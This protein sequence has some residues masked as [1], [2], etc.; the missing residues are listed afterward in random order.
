MSMKAGP[1][2]GPKGI[3]VA[4]AFAA[5]WE[6]LFLSP[7]H[8]DSALSKQEKNMKSILARSVPSI[9]QRPVSQAEALGIGVPEGE[10][11][12]LSPEQASKWRPAVLMAERIYEGMANRPVDASPVREDFPPWMVEEWE[13]H[14]GPDTSL[15]LIEALGR[16]APLS[17]R[18]AR[19]VGSKELLR[20]L[21]EGSRLP[22]AAA[23]SDFA[24]LGVRLAGYAPVLG[25]EAYEKGLFE[26]QDEGSQVMALF[27]L[28]PEKFAPLLRSVPGPVDLSHFKRVSAKLPDD[29]PALTV[30][31]ACAGAGGKSLALADA[32]RGKGRIFSY[33]ISERKLQALRRR[34]THAGYNNIQAVALEEGKEAETLRKFRRTAQVVLVDA[35]CTGWGVLRRNPDIKWRQSPAALERLPQVQARLLSTYSDLV[36]PGGRLV[37]G[38]CTFRPAETSKI[39]DDFVAAHPDF[40]PRQGGYLGP[41][42]C[43]GFFMQVFERAP[44]GEKK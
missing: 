34:A 44:K 30:V 32:L 41:G 27:A 1:K 21:T 10:P 23:E 28:W 7:V 24:P 3:Q 2:A 22:V 38:V 9:L 20:I 11:W 31:D 29:P 13:L 42:P 15:H 37:F 17:L 19:S 25:T 14:W 43:D 6:K 40:T 36:A 35:P 16:E 5:V 39:V 33:D 8:L 18:A 12:S 26:I 4:K